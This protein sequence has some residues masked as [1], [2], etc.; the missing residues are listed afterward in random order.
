MKYE[1]IIKTNEEEEDKRV[2][3]ENKE[4]EKIE[5]LQSEL[6]QLESKGE[7][8]SS[9]ICGNYYKFFLKEFFL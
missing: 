9:N 7:L 1:I 3:I 4:K 2:K 5:A 8:T 6:E